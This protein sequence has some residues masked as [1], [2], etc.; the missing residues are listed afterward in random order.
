M[1]IRYI[2]HGS[3]VAND[4]GH[5]LLLY[6]SDEREVLVLNLTA[7]FVW[8]FCGTPHSI[9]EIVQAVSES[10]DQ[11]E[12]DTA[13]RDVEHLFQEHRRLFC[14]TN[15]PRLNTTSEVEPG[16]LHMPGTKRNPDDPL[17]DPVKSSG[18]KPGYKKPEVQTVDEEHFIQQSQRC[19]HTVDPLQFGDS[20]E[21]CAGEATR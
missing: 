5:E 18:P 20:W 16:S 19:P 8:L 10:F 4:L 21:G 12:F 17:T 15:L 3:F 13:S 6:G 1:E 14:S 9:P 7:K 2:R 11:L